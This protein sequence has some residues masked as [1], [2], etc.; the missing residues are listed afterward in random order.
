VSF[1]VIFS[2][3][4]GQKCDAM[5]QII[6]DME[7]VW[8]MPIHLLSDSSS[9]TR[10]DALTCHKEWREHVLPSL[11]KASH[12][13]A[14]LFLEIAKEYETEHIAAAAQCKEAALIL[15]KESSRSKGKS[16]QSNGHAYHS[17]CK[18]EGDHA[19][20]KLKCRCHRKPCTCGAKSND[21]SAVSPHPVVEPVLSTKRARSPAD[22]V[23]NIDSESRIC[24]PEPVFDSAEDVLLARDDSL[25][26]FC[27]DALESF[28][29]HR[30]CEFFLAPGL[31]LLP[32]ILIP[33][34][35]CTR[36]S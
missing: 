33:N 18:S 5:L 34:T 7:L 25:S 16:S 19:V 3:N 31:K 36:L 9:Q 27:K 15:Q 13:D 10:S 1:F 4:S 8:N 17:D 21:S 12:K 11:A 22:G 29:K 32:F 2:L 28:M 26:Q 35:V 20:V 30:R 6:R 14:Q 24:R 23:S